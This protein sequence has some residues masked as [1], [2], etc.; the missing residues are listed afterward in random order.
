MRS[1][2]ILFCGWLAVASSGQ[3]GGRLRVATFRVDA[4]PPLQSP[5]CSGNVA[6]AS[7]IVDRLTA[8]GL[9]LLGAGQ[10]IVLC[11]VD[12]V[13]ISNASHDAWRRA[14]AGATGTSPDRV[15]VHVV[16]QH[17]APWAD[18]SAEQLLAEHGLSGAMFDVAHAAKTRERCAAAARLAIDR[19]RPVT[20]VSHGL[21]PVEKVAS[22]RRILGANGKVRHVRYSSCREQDAIVAPEG[23]V[24]PFV[25]VVGLWSGERPVA[26]LSWYACHPQSFYGKGGVCTEFVGLAR[27][28]REAALGGVPH[29]HFDGAGGDVA[30]GKYNRGWPEPETRLLLAYRLAGA[31]RTAWEQGEKIALNA[32]EVEWRTVAVRLPLRGFL[33]EKELVRKLG[34][35]RGSL[36][37]RIRAARDLAWARRVR[38]GHR[39]TLGCLAL[40]PIRVV[41][42]PG[43]LFVAY[44]LAAQKMRPDLFVGMAAYGDMGP[45]YIGTA[46]AYEQ[47]GYETTWRPEEES[48]VSRVAPSVEEV[49][50]RAMRELLRRQ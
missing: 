31:M 4:T 11:T 19:A 15:S 43:E 45:G 33:I 28:V 26:V 7:H 12:W 1:A 48:S 42:M 50:T 5:L 13:G 36:R 3:S 32:G 24:D 23:Q 44:Q 29:L 46:L 27:S 34:D 22:T 14:L 37:K 30:C 17:D 35:P 9:V 39:I 2:T 8:R 38:A 49:L 20:H 47:G 6:A 41:H 10:P 25:R 40:G 16:H 18:A 21:A